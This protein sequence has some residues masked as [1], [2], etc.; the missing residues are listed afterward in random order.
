MSGNN[1]ESNQLLQREHDLQQSQND[2]A[3]SEAS[4][5]MALAGQWRTPPLPVFPTSASS[6]QQTTMQLGPLVSSTPTVPLPPDPLQV[7][8]LPIPVN[9]EDYAKALQEAYRR[10]AEAAAAL[11]QQQQ[12]QHV[13]PSAS[14]PN[15]V[16][17]STITGVTVA[18][19][20]T[21]SAMEAPVI[22]SSAPAPI[23]SMP[24]TAPPIAPFSITQSASQPPLSA[25]VKVPPPSSAS[26]MPP[27]HPPTSSTGISSAGGPSRSMS[28][29]DMASYAAREKAEEE[30]RQKR[31]A[32][33]RASARLRRL[34]KKNL[35]RNNLVKHG[36]TCLNLEL[37]LIRVWDWS[38]NLTSRYCFCR[39]TR[40]KRKLV[41]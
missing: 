20:T 31:L 13:V 34:R 36:M 25:N 7:T 21:P 27:L 33:N 38:V 14:C 5:R 41:S 2:E 15:F 1:L 4:K 3:N 11:V 23:A 16:N 17:I 12:Q 35:V 39:W 10:G 18:A 19:P 37:W 29:P 32:R 8:S 24:A 9:S 22:T 28:L 26:M 6:S 40:T 30:K